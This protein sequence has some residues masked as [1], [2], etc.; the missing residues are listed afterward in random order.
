MM[1]FD[2]KDFVEQKIQQNGT[3]FQML[4]ET[5]KMCLQMA[6]LLDAEHG[7]TMAPQ[8]MQQFGMAAETMAANGMIP[9]E[10]PELSAE[11]QESPV[12]RKARE[13]A[14]QTTAPR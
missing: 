12:T 3:L 13:Q 4:Q 9:Q 11:S 6:Q 7:S 5:Q 1:D 8:L 14:A 10:Q 2:R